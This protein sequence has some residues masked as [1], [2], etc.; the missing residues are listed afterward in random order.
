VPMEEARRPKRL[1]LS[2][3]AIWR[4]RK[5]ILGMWGIKC[6]KCGTLQYDYGA[7]N[8]TP[9]RICGVCQAKDD[10]DD[11]CFSDKQGT[12]FSYT[13]DNLAPS[14]DPPATVVLVDFDGGGRSFFDL[15]DRDPAEVKVGMKVEMTF[16]KVRFE[17]GLSNYFWKAK[18]VR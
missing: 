11:V 12:V 5:T 17:N 16:R 18:P 13:M 10:F 14:N 4:D 8:T 6:R 9:I 7:M 3:S 15:T 2:L 1:E